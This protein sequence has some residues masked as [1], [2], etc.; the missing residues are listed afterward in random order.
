MVASLM[1]ERITKMFPT[2]THTFVYLLCNMCTCSHLRLSEL[3]LKRTDLFL[4]FMTNLLSQ[5]GQTVLQLQA[6]CSGGQAS[7]SH[8]LH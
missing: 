3:F 2:F 1:T 5:G 6:G 8:A 4:R 7:F